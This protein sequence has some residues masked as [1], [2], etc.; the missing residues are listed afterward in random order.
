MTIPIQ[1]LL[2]LVV[3]VGGIP[4]AVMG[5]PTLTHR[6]SITALLLLLIV[7][8]SLHL[9]HLLSIVPRS[10]QLLSSSPRSGWQRVCASKP[11]CWPRGYGTP[12][13]AS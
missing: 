2:I 8:R 4:W 13:V 6:G 11:F 7:P 1:M 10:T 3:L 12:K 5:P 9:H